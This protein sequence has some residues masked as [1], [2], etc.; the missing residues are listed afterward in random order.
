MRHFATSATNFSISTLVL[1]KQNRFKHKRRFSQVQGEDRH[2]AL[3]IH[4]K[5][6]IDKTTSLCSYHRSS[7]A[8]SHYNGKI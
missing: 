8:L 6:S 2:F 3:D 5:R 7:V 4:W 1:Q